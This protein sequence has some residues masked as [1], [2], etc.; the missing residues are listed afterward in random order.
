[1][2]PLSDTVNHAKFQDIEE[3]R[4]RLA[5]YQLETSDGRPRRGRNPEEDRA[6]WVVVLSTDG[7]Q[8]RRDIWVDHEAWSFNKERWQPE[9]GIWPTWP[10]RPADEVPSP[11]SVLSGVQDYWAEAG[12]R[13]RDSAKWMAAVLGAALAA[14]VGTSPLALVKGDHFGAA[15]FLLGALGLLALGITLFLVM[16]VMRPKAVSLTDIQSARLR[17]FPGALGKWQDTVES[18]Q[19]MYLPCGV[20]CLTS[21]RQSMIIEKMTLV[22]LALAHEKPTGRKMAAELQEAQAA[23]AARLMELRSAAARIT[24]I[25]EY[26]ALRSRNTWA[27]YCG[28]VCGLIGTAAIIAAFAWPPA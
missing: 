27:T 11:E 17:R 9:G 3:L 26:Y 15:S 12:N 6:C 13:L 25:G 1:M 21:L 18:H 22:A 19:D 16:Q 5:D 23:R 4:E 14:L 2:L 28:I 8:I 24:T 7:R 10:A 20:R